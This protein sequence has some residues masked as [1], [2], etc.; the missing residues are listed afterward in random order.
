MLLSRKLTLTS[1]FIAALI[2]GSS[3][4]AL[5]YNGGGAAKYADTWAV[6]DNYHNYP[7]FDADCTNFVSQAESAGGYPFRSGSGADSWWIYPYGS[8]TGP[9]GWNESLSWINVVGYYNFLM[10]DRPGGFPEGTA[11][12]SSTNYFTPNA[13]ETGDV[14]FFDWGQGEGMSHAV[15]QSGIGNDPHLYPHQVWYGNYIDAHTTNHYHAFWSL[16]PYNAA[17]S[18]T[19]ISFV[20]IDPGNK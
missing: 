7:V 9:A 2:G 20:H 12:G 19:T 6:T 3:S 18:S 14:L 15:I 13:V 10:A 11:P 8:S 16:K 17:W 5:A 4:P 1:L